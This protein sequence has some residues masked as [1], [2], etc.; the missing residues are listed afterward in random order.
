MVGGEGQLVLCP[1]L[2]LESR[3]VGCSERSESHQQFLLGD[4]MT[5]N[6]IEGVL[7]NW[8]AQA[9]S[10]IGQLEPGIQPANFVAR[11]F[12]RWWSS[13]VEDS[14]ADVEDAINRLH[15]ALERLGG[16]E[17]CGEALHE[18]S[19]ANEA[20]ADLRVLLGQPKEPQ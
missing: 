18:L 14:L 8:I 6:E 17:K 5:T 19:H 20:L 7:A 3:V 4:E 12:L 15:N 10:P 9:L 16:W 13:H 1:Q 11:N 2:R